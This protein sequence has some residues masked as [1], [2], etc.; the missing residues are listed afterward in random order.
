MFNFRA[1]SFNKFELSGVMYWW[2]ASIQD[3]QAFKSAPGDATVLKRFFRD[4]FVTFR[5]T[6]KRIAFSE[7]VNF[8]RVYCTCV[9]MQI[10]N[11]HDGHVTTFWHHSG[12]CICQM[13]GYRL[14]R[15]AKGTP[16][17]YRLSIGTIGFG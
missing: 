5:Q 2:W 10:F 9:Y 14:S 17:E 8:L 15:L 1:V 3:G 16:S 11:F 13:P 12:A 7:S 4:N 6:S